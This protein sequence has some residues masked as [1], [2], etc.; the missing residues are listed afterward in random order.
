VNPDRGAL[1]ALQN[2]L[3]WTI[4]GYDTRPTPEAVEL[5]QKDRLDILLQYRQDEDPADR[6]RV[7]HYHYLCHTLFRI[8]MTPVGPE[9][10]MPTYLNME[11]QICYPA[12]VEADWDSFKAYELPRPQPKFAANRY[13]YQVPEHS[14]A[15]EHPWQR[16]AQHWI[17][18]YFHFPW[19]SLNDPGD[20]LIDRDVRRE[21]QVV[22]SSGLSSKSFDRADYIWYRNPGMSVP[23]VFH[24]QVFWI[25][26]A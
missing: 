22:L 2:M 26:R 17:L 19:E 11:G 8:P 10:H 24:V 9:V 23:E 6:P 7:S 21:L 20:E 12:W 25:A 4:G 16:R 15:A 13:P 3:G 18:W 1:Q 5:K 14:P